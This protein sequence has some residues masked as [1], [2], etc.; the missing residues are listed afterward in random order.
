MSKYYKMALSLLILSQSVR[1]VVFSAELL[2]YLLHH[3]CRR[4]SWSGEQP[5]HFRWWQCQLAQLAATT[6]G[7]QT[8]WETKAVENEVKPWWVDKDRSDWKRQKEKE[9]EKQTHIHTKLLN[10]FMRWLIDPKNLLGKSHQPV[11]VTFYRQIRRRWYEI[12]T[13]VKK[14]HQSWMSSNQTNLNNE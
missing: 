5:L 4:W 10:P 9:G 7:K 11:L 8:Q 3:P 2:L 12:Y 1:A 6:T 13:V 14:V